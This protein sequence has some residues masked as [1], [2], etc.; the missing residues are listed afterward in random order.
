VGPALAVC[1]GSDAS[2]P[3]PDYAAPQTLYLPG[4]LAAS[5]AFAAGFQCSR[6]LPAGSSSTTSL[7]ACQYGCRL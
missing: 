4:R 2:R 7:I 1:P 5:K 3:L 6:G